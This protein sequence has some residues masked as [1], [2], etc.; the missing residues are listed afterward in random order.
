MEISYDV[1]SFKAETEKAKRELLDRVLKGV[2]LACAHVESVAKENCPKKTGNLMQ[3]IRSEAVLE[4]DTAQGAVGTN[5]EYAVYVHEGTGM[6]SRTGMGRAGKWRYRDTA[7]QWHTTSGSP[8][9]PFLENAYLREGG[10]VKEI[11][12]SALGG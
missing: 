4:G 2:N 1:K 9:N 12:E 6:Y 3:S 8:P 7:G 11:V 10:T 5:V